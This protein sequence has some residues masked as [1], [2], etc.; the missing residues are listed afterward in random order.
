MRMWILLLVLVLLSVAAPAA[1]QPESFTVGALKVVYVS[2]PATDIIAANMYFRGGVAVAGLEKAGIERLALLVATRATKNYP[3]DVLSAALERM[4]TRLNSAAGPDYSSIDMQCVKKNFAESWKIFTD[5]ILNPSFDS[6]LVE[7]ERERTVAGIRQ[8]KDV[9]DQYL[10]QLAVETFYRENPYS[11]DPSGTVRTVRSFSAKDL[12]AFMQSRV[13]AAQMLLVV[14]GNVTRSEL[15]QMVKT[16]FG[17]LPQG[18]FTVSR[19]VPV[20]H[21]SPM[22]LVVKRDLPTNYITGLFPAPL[23]GSPASYAMIMA[24]SIL[25]DRLFEEVRTKRSLSYAASATAGA[26]F[27]NYAGIYV[28]T[29]KPETTIAVMVGELKKLQNE[30]VPAKTLSDK[31]NLFFTGY[32]L[33]VETNASQADMLARYELSGKGYEEGTKLM[34]NIRKVTAEDIQKVCNEY[35][36]NLQF[37][38]IGNPVSL[39]LN[40]FMY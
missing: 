14:C 38:L 6:A 29:T 27:S 9:P 12:Q 4:D 33:G 7:R 22:V 19:P 23:F 31:K 8:V 17:I 2:N 10:T 18:S 11:I 40:P 5:V 24:R 20:Q 28:T 21:S 1:V 16:S 13:T 26:M 36:H 39:Q 34:E 15:E 3:L 37:V 35:I 30:P 32:Y 25:G